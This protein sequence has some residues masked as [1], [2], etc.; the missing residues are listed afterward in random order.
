MELR[1][2]RMSRT[3]EYACDKEYFN[4]TTKT[5][6]LVGRRTEV[7]LSGAFLIMMILSVLRF[8]SV[9]WNC[10]IPGGPQSPCPLSGLFSVSIA[11]SHFSLAV[12]P[13]AREPRLASPGR[14]SC[15][16]AYTI[17]LGCQHD[18]RDMTWAACHAG[19]R[20]SSSH[21][22]VTRWSRNNTEYFITHLAARAQ[23][24]CYSYT[25]HQELTVVRMLGTQCR[26]GHVN[27]FPFNISR[28]G[29]C[30]LLSGAPSPPSSLLPLL[31]LP[32]LV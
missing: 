4:H 26:D 17:Q 12:R 7:S 31:L 2:G 8:P 16:L 14:G 27:S 23:Y 24:S 13:D 10:I 5:F 25:A 20:E 32:W 6:T 11:Q 30:A 18:R 3:K 15:S 29:D 9:S 21:Q 19:L 22:C 28:E 1:L